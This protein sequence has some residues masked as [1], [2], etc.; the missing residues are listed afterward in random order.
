M[1][2]CDCPRCRYYPL[3]QSLDLD[4][5]NSQQPSNHHHHC[6]DQQQ[7]SVHPQLSDSSHYSAQYPHD[8]YSYNMNV[9]APQSY[10]DCRPSCLTVSTPPV[11]PPDFPSIS[12]P[13]AIARLDYRLGYET[14]AVSDSWDSR[15]GCAAGVYGAAVTDTARWSSCGW[16]RD[17]HNENDATAAAAAGACVSDE[18]ITAVKKHRR[19]TSIHVCSSPGCGKSY[20]KSSHL[21][22]H[23]RTHTGEKPYGCDWVGCGWQFARSDE[24][25]RHYRKH[26]GDRPFNCAVCRRTFARSDHLAL[27]MKRHQ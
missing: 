22:A 6:H 23:V 3:T 16:Q 24:L 19:A 4:T 18:D 17:Y 26:T 5:S 2:T 10:S 14:A 12:R 8:I 9:Q 7:Y 11:S 15:P 21:K 27:H 1:A 25:T 13:A 20:T